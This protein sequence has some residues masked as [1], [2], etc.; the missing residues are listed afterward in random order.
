MKVGVYINE[1]ARVARV[2]LDRDGRDSRDNSLRQVCRAHALGS[3]HT[4]KVSSAPG[5]CCD[6]N[7]RLVIHVS[8][9]SIAR[10]VIHV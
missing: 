9:T 6:S 1:R 4:L 7:T 5:S 10:L 2:S 8:E 3:V